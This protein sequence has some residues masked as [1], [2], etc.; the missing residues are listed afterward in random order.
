MSGRKVLVSSLNEP[1][2]DADAQTGYA[3]AKEIVRVALC[4]TCA[5]QW[6]GPLG[7]NGTNIPP[8]HCGEC[9]TALEASKV[10]VSS[11]PDDVYD[12]L[13]KRGWSGREQISTEDAFD[14]YC[15]W[16]G[17]ISWGPTLR[18]VLKSLGW[19]PPSE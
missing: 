6:Y 7:V 15:N 11:L 3:P 16:H 19:T 12:A 13:I 5:K 8:T 9:C 14:E 2:A 18:Q 17:L 1:Q 4:P 10:L